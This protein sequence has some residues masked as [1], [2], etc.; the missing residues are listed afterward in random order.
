MEIIYCMKCHQKRRFK[1]YE[2]VV[3]DIKDNTGA[4]IVESQCVSFCGPGGKNHFCVIDD[5]LVVDQDYQEFIKKLK[6]KGDK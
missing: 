4:Q 1:A 5:Q 6:F 3:K 2:D